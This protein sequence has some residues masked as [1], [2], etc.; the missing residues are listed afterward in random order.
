MVETQS[1]HEICDAM[2]W[3]KWHKKKIICFKKKKLNQFNALLPIL[4]HFSPTTWWMTG[5]DVSIS[6]W[7]KLQK[8]FNY[9][10]FNSIHGKRN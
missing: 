2:K 10:T 8:Y 5:T 3:F 7:L 9:C 6:V 1:N 4:V